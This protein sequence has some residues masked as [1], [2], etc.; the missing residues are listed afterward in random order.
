MS[1]T[2]HELWY[3]DAP[4]GLESTGPGFTVV[5]MTRGMPPGL[6]SFLQQMSCYDTFSKFKGH[7]RCCLSHWSLGPDRWY[8]L[9]RASAAKGHSH[10]T[11]FFCHHVALHHSQIPAGNPA[12]LLRSSLMQTSWD[13]Q[14]EWLERCRPVPRVATGPNACRN[15][16][17][18][19]GDAGVAGKFLYELRNHASLYVPVKQP[20][21][22]LAL[23]EEALGL[24]PPEEQWEYGFT[25]Y[26]TADVEKQLNF[27]FFPK[28]LPPH[29][30]VPSGSVFQTS[31]VELRSDE[32]GQEHVEAARAGRRVP[33][34]GSA[35]VVGGDFASAAPPISFSPAHPAPLPGQVNP[36]AVGPVPA[37]FDEDLV[38]GLAPEGSVGSPSA[39]AS[40]KS[41]KS[42]AASDPPKRRIGTGILAAGMF[43]AGIL[44]TLGA[45]W[46]AIRSG[47]RELQSVQQ[48]NERLK[49]EALQFDEKLKTATRERQQQL[50]QQ[51]EESR[52]ALAMI[53]RA[54]KDLAQALP[55]QARSQELSNALT[56][57]PG[58]PDAEYLTRV[59]SMV[60]EGSQAYVSQTTAQVTALQNTLQKLQN[61]QTTIRQELAEARQAGQQLEERNRELLAIAPELNDPAVTELLELIAMMRRRVPQ[62]AR[63]ATLL[64]AE[65]QPAIELQIPSGEAALKKPVTFE[66]PDEAGGLRI[67]D[68][69]MKSVPGGFS[70][71]VSDATRIRLKFD[72]QQFGEIESTV[73]DGQPVLLFRWRASFP[74]WQDD[75]WTSLLKD[76][77]YL[78]QITFLSEAPRQSVGNSASSNSKP[79]PGSTFAFDSLV[80]IVWG[81]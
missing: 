45:L 9:T 59:L 81:D 28:P 21:V 1:A 22:A 23:I 4:G 20:D 56:N 80:P 7:V 60:Q 43:F 73:R 12:S 34:V 25:S 67:V 41:S 53:D 49:L 70:Y 46:P 78:L 29:I 64:L 38:D 68:W 13:G 5:K 16:E 36:V 66:I 18:E 6:K 39:H 17:R 47:Q 14:T 79:K 42:N 32:L 72:N 30:Q 76:H 10:R 44:V 40:S 65:A 62:V 69:P 63:M 11:A 52:A 74:Y 27:R 71:S 54:V 26:L 33:S 31:V 75:A 37:E 57:P 61:E 55:G 24:L 8:I 2:S 15:W 51:V 50:N 3:A 58:P 77:L 19:Y 48:E 35:S